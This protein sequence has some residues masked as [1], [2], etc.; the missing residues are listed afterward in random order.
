MA[1]F[2]LVIGFLP[3]VNRIRQS[4]RISN[5]LRTGAVV[6]IVMSMIICFFATNYVGEVFV[7]IS[8]IYLLLTLI[9]K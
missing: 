9:K 4:Q 1:V 8:V 3:F 5:F 7:G 2:A 6:L